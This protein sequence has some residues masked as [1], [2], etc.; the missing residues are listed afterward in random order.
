MRVKIPINQ[1]PNPK[2]LVAGYEIGRQ[3]VKAGTSVG[4]NLEEADDASSVKD[5]LYKAGISR[6]EA[7]ESR[8]WLKTLTFGIWA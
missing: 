6:R 4:S 2:W 8:Y 7:K 1:N 5:F 3:L